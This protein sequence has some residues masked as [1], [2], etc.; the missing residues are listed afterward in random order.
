MV[1]W[2]LRM[3][4]GFM[5]LLGVLGLVSTV[6]GLNR[7]SAF[8][9]SATAVVGPVAAAVLVGAT[10][11]LFVAFFLGALVTAYQLD[12]PGQVP[13]RRLKWIAWIAIFFVPV[14]TVAAAATFLALRRDDVADRLA[15]A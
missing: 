13:R 15:A 12:E 5:G 7:A 10:T 4:R 1:E 11:M 9:E 14:G 2:N 8:Y 6:V 3:V